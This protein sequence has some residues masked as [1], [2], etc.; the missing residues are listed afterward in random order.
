MN[1]LPISTNTFSNH[2]FFLSLKRKREEEEVVDEKHNP[3]KV[4]KAVGEIGK[5]IVRSIYFLKPPSL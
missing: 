3:W 1:S 2:H 4:L 5:G